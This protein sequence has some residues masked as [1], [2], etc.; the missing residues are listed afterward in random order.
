MAKGNYRKAYTD[1][2]ISRIEWIGYIH[3][4][5]ATIDAL[6]WVLGK[7]DRYD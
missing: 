2:K 1:G 7:N 6:R 5:N 4:C 3:D